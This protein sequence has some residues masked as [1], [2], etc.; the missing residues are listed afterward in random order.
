MT[1]LYLTR[2]DD[3]SDIHKATMKLWRCIYLNPATLLNQKSQR[4]AIKI[5]LI[6]LLTPRFAKKIMQFISH[7]RAVNDPRLEKV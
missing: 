7:I 5:L 1:Q 3:E 6:G 2:I 4:L